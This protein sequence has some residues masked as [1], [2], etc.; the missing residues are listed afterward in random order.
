MKSKIGLIAV[1][2]CSGLLLSA[3]TN[4]QTSTDTETN[5]NQVQQ[6]NGEGQPSG[7][8]Q[9]NAMGQQQMDLAAAAET[10]GVTEEEL[11]EAL[12]MDDMAEI[13]PGEEGTPGA[14]PSGEPVQMDLA[15]AAET[16]G[17][18]EDELKEALGWDDMQQGG[19]QGGMGGQGP[20]GTAPAN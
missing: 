20:N 8:P 15:G 7:A 3:C 4:K 19:P 6:Q 5:G 14:R 1:V 2:L 17:V 16:L 9:G 13:T 18:T 12:G 11:R 10:L